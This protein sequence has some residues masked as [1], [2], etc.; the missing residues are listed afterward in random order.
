MPLGDALRKVGGLFFEM[1]ESSPKATPLSDEEFRKAMSAAEPGPQPRTIEQVVRDQ[2]GPNLD[3]IK[4]TP[5]VVKAAP[6]PV[7]ADGTVDFNA[8]YQ[9]ASVPAAPFTAEQILELLNSLPPELPIESRRQTIKITLQAMAKSVPVTAEGVVTD[10]SRKVAALASYA[11]G[12]SKQADEFVAKAQLDIVAL[13][14]QIAD[15][16][17]AIE[18]AKAQQTSMIEA[19]RAESDHLDDVLEFFSLDIPPSKYAK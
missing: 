13:E 9:M 1:D 10:A 14:A 3:Q 12:Y 16:Q 7:R 6:Q 18:N 19:C 17:K 8:I 4:V 2:P 15:K 11:D 5:E